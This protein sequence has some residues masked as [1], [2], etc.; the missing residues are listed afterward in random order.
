MPA[1][2]SD[3]LMDMDS[4]RLQHFLAAF[5]H[6]SLG[7]AAAELHISQP[8]LSKSIHQL[9]HELGVKLFDR[10]PLGLAPTI[11]GEALAVHAQSVQ[12]ELDSAEREI[13][14]LRGAAKGLVRVGV[15]PSVAASPLP[16]VAANLMRSRPSIQLLVFEGLVET[17]V[18]ALRRGEL[19][20]V[21]GGWARGMD[22]DLKTEP[23]FCD[24]VR[25]WGRAGHPLQ[26][27][28]VELAQL[29]AYSW[30]TPPPAQFWLDALDRAFSS[31]GLAAPVP[32]VVTTSASLIIGL[33]ERSDALTYLPTQVFAAHRPDGSMAPLDVAAVDQAID[34]NV[35]RRASAGLTPAALAFVA[36]LH[37]T[38]C[39]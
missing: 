8:G 32:A 33:L 12:S 31:V 3:G 26:G 23:V 4:R 24:T 29:L 21:V 2:A 19:D 11:F 1:N 35:T 10:T 14:M 7:R 17:H 13:A 18:P 15:T 20:L 28:P 9:E 30:V 6:R 39:T 16:A 34:I 5:R 27:G 36:A 37:E 38:A 22:P 25:V